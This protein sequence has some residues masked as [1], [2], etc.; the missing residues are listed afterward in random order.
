MVEGKSINLG[1]ILHW[2]EYDAIDRG[3][4]GISSEVIDID[5]GKSI[6]LGLINQKLKYGNVIY[7]GIGSIPFIIIYSR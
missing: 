6:N 2:I 1:L 7:R 5:E 4:G 3:M